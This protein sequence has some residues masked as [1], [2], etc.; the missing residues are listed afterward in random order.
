MRHLMI[1]IALCL[2]IPGCSFGPSAKS[3]DGVIVRNGRGLVARSAPPYVKKAVAAANRIAGKPY[4]WGGGH[5]TR[6][7]SGYDCSGATSYVLREAGLLN[8]SLPSKGFYRYGRRGEGDWITVWVRDG[9]VFLTI[10]GARFD[11]M[12]EDSHGGPKWFTSERST[13]KF[14]PRRPK[15]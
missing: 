1:G 9:H 8:G 10:G 4:K 15:T 2:L 6:I 3:R 13:R 12:G 14:T 11:A 5:G 7:D